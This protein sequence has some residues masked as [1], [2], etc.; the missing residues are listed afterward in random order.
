MSK[1][2]T[3]SYAKAKDVFLSLEFGNQEVISIN[4]DHLK[5]FR[6]HLSEFIKRKNSDKLFYSRQLGKNRVLVGR[7][8]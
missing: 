6:K 7:I 2:I 4:D 8:K 1:D 5:I 3:G